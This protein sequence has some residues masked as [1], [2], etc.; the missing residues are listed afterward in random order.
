LNGRPKLIRIEERCKK[1]RQK[2][3]KVIKNVKIMDKK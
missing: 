2:G 3:Y 1:Q